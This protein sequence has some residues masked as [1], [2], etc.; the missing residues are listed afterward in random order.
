[1]NRLS[2]SPLMGLR[3]I[4]VLR[5]GLLGWICCGGVL[6]FLGTRLIFLTLRCPGGM[7][8]V[9]TRRSFGRLRAASTLLVCFCTF[10]ICLAGSRSAGIGLTSGNL[11]FLSLPGT[12]E[13][14]PPSFLLCFLLS[15]WRWGEIRRLFRALRGLICLSDWLIRC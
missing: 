6:P 8:L 1:M 15:F 11:R 7:Y 3:G 14:L 13:F 10:R 2:S 4:L 9:W 5:A 12:F